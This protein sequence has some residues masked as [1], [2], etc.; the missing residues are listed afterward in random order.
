[1]GKVSTITGN[2]Y[3][4]VG[5]PTSDA[6]EGGGNYEARHYHIGDDMAAT[7]RSTLIGRSSHVGM[8]RFH[9]E[10]ASG[11]DLGEHGGMDGA[12]RAIVAHHRASHPRAEAVGRG[13]H[14]RMIHGN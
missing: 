7:H 13:K 4:A 2:G 6:I 5:A 1:M 10:S 14:S 3:H 9:A 11:E 8:G 12:H